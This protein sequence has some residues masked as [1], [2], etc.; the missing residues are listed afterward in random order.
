LKRIIYIGNKPMKADNIAGTGLT[1]SKGEVHEVEDDAKAAKLLDYAGVW[2]DA[3]TDYKPLETP[4][5]QISAP[6][7]RAMIV[8]QGGEE[9]SPFWDPITIVVPAEVFKSLQDKETIAV[10]MTPDDA[11]AYEAFKNGGNVQESNTPE[12]DPS[13]L[14]KRSK[15]YKEWAAANPDEAAKLLKAA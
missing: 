2:A 8:P 14:D 12:I 15:A 9:V 10:F 5:E 6:N 1:W 13:T 3:D 4:A 11:D 7:P